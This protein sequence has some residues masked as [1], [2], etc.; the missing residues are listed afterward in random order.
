M[1]INNLANERTFRS[2]SLINN[3]YHEVN[4]K[5]IFLVFV[6]KLYQGLVGI[7]CSEAQVL[8]FLHFKIDQK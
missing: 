6:D 8:S 7:C 4:F 1:L 5:Y 2:C 3:I